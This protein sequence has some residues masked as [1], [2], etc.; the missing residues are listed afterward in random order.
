[1]PGIGEPIGFGGFFAPVPT[2][3]P[4]AP[5]A[6][7]G[8]VPVPA[9][10]QTQ[11]RLRQERLDSFRARTTESD[12]RQDETRRQ[13]QEERD[14]RIFGRPSAAFLAQLIGQRLTEGA[15]PQRQAAQ[16][17]ALAFSTTQSLVDGPLVDRNRDGPIAPYRSRLDISV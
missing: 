7:P 8:A 4:G 12:S 1:M 16:S 9:D 11:E 14:Q 17:A 6:Q 13:S 5:T 10:V 2:Q 3:R 15:P